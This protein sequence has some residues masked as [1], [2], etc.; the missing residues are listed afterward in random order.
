MS[1]TVSVAIIGKS[2]YEYVIIFRTYL[3]MIILFGLECAVIH[4]GV[5]VLPFR[6][7]LCDIHMSIVTNPTDMTTS[8][9]YVRDRTSGE[10][11]CIS[12]ESESNCSIRIGWN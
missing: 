5:V 1:V 9:A 6:C 4:D 10:R 3:R 2:H 7:M 8:P 11:G 12:V